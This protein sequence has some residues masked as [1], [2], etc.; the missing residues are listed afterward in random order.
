V[1]LRLRNAIGLGR[2]DGEMVRELNAHLALLED[3]Y[4]RRG[5][6][7]DEAHRQAR[8]TLG[9]VERTK[10]LHRAARS[11]RPFEDA[12]RDVRYAVRL[13]RRAPAFTITATLSLAVAIG[14]TTTVFTAVNALLI[15]TAPGVAD[16]D[17][18]VDIS[19]MSDP[20]GVEPIGLTQY[21]SI[22]DRATRVQDVFAYALNL[23]PMSWVD[24]A[25]DPAQ[26][27]FTDRVTPNFFKALGVTPAI[28][29]VFTDTDRGSVVVLSYR[30]WRDRLHADPAVI[31]SPIRL[32]D[33]AFIVVGVA[34]AEFHGNTVLAP[35]LWIPTADDTQPL[36]L[37]LVGARLR[38]G[39]TLAEARAEMES[40]GH[41]LSADLMFRRESGSLA[42]LRVDRSSPVPYGVRVIVGGFLGLL[43][44][45]VSLVLIVACANVAGLLLVRGAG[46]ARETA[47]RI[48][49][50]VSRGR[51]VRQ[52]LTETLVLFA[53]SGLGGLL[54]SRV[55]AAATLRLL[56][57]LPLPSDPSLLMDG[58]VV[59]FALGVSLAAAVTF[60]LA[61]AIRTTRVDV[62]SLLKAQEQGS[63]S[64]L[65]LRRVFVVAQVALSVVL[66]VV[67]GLLARTLAHST[68]IGVGFD[69]HGVDAVSIDLATA[70]YTS[71]TGSDFTGALDRRLRLMPDLQAVAIASGTPTSG[72]MGFQVGVPGVVP[73]DGRALF[74]VFG[75]IVT[76]GYF[77]TLRIPVIAGRDFAD[78]DTGAAP[79]TV[80][81]SEKTVRQ[82]W[83]SR[84]PQDVIGQQLGLQPNLID[85]NN[86]NRAP[87]LISMTIVGVVGDLRFGQ[88]SHPYIYLPMQQHY[89]SEITIL[90]R[91]RDNQRVV[92]R[93]REQLSAMDRRLSV[94]TA[95]SLEDA[96]GP[97]ETQLRISAAIAGSLGLVGVLLA[98]VGVY[99]VTSYMVARRT[100]EI[101]IRIALGADRPGVVRLAMGEAARLLVVGASAGL[102]LSAGAARVLRGFKFGIMTS[103]PVPFGAAIMLFVLVGLL[104]SW[105]PVRRAL[106]IDPSRALRYE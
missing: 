53:M 37:G 7:S 51:L 27:V 8:V 94:L 73:P 81:V 1:I 66:V 52:L 26:A 85:R 82:F 103:D 98:A 11:F 75:N 69:P 13:L 63:A 59:V 49:M 42:K 22:R 76:P 4:R 34:R 39:V 44:A 68:G 65:R 48:A 64:A 28:G 55:M 47:V 67:G 89:R 106:S 83:P 80:I 101:G 14:A 9:G 54:L 32:G 99:G 16:P 92:S 12:H 105:V 79:R 95:E 30:F 25:G 45:I 96:G 91:A 19:R 10:E 100:R 2:S 70:G 31:G 104:A 41:T 60:G 57:S 78:T 61:P 18:V 3:E 56:P 72:A 15:R 74:E 58:R 84:V 77:A 20:V 36:N 17:R 50:G 43:M 35:D 21:A 93:V 5:L 86:P 33:H 87:T 29:R 90:A 38:P 97:V 102:L 23:S 24:R 6:S 46:R 40:I 88:A 62:L 71:T